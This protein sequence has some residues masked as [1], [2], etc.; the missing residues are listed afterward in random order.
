MNITQAEDHFRIWPTNLAK[1]HYTSCLISWKSA[2]N[3]NWKPSPLPWTQPLL[4]NFLFQ[5]TDK[6]WGVNPS[7]PACL[8]TVYPAEQVFAADRKPF[9]RG[10]IKCQASGCG[11]VC[12]FKKLNPWKEKLFNLTM[13]GAKLEP[14]L[15]ITILIIF[16]NLIQCP[17]KWADCPRNAQSW[18][19]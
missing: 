19:V 18:R 7:C 2:Q 4:V 5:M 12:T 6:K 17:K 9:H 11:S 10:C 15:F 3:Q 1:D 14:S 13:T 8:K 16:G